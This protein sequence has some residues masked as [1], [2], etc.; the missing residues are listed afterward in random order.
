MGDDALVITA[1]S[2]EPY[3]IHCGLQ[4]WRGGRIFKLIYSTTSTPKR[5]PLTEMR[6][7]NLAMNTGLGAMAGTIQ[8]F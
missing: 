5:I 3:Y 7:G 2:D 4:V 8:G 6:A 1:C